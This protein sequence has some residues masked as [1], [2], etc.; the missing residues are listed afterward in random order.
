M[1][2][3][4]DTVV[5]INGSGS[6]PIQKYFANRD[7]IRWEYISNQNMAEMLLAISY[8]PHL[9]MDVFLVAD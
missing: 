4:A 1:Q 2:L 9:R 5:T 3:H 8:P 6:I 7:A